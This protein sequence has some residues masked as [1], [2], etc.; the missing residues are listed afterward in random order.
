MRSLLI[1]LFALCTT[2]HAATVDPDLFAAM[3]WRM[4]G[5]FRG[6]R[7]L[8]V[9]GVPGQP[10]HFYSG[11][12]DG[13]V[14][15][16]QDAGRTWQPIFDAMPIGSIGAIAV[17]P[18]NPKVIYVGAGEADMRSDIGYGNGMYK[19]VDA[20]GTWTRIGLVDSH[21]IG[22]ILVDP[23]NPD[24]LFVAALGHAYGANEE[25]GVFRSTDGG[26]S[27]QKILYKDADTGAIDLAFGEDSKTM[28]AAMWQTR[29]PPWNVYPPSNGP[30]AGLY[31]SVDGGN[32]WTQ[33]TGHGFPS[34]GLGRI[35]IAAAPADPKRIY[36]IVDAKAGGLYRSDDSGANWS[37]VSNDSRIF[38]RGWYF[39]GI[40]VDP[41]NSDVVYSCDV[42][43]YKSVDGGKTFLPL[44]GAPGGDDYHALWID[45]DD[46]SR[47][48]T[49]A[50]QGAVVT[51]NGGLTWSSWHNQ[52][53]GQFYHVITD[54]QFPYRVYGAQQDSGAAAVPSRTT[55]FNGMNMMQFREVTAGGESG[56]I[57]PDPLNPEIIYG[58]KVAKLDTRTEQTEDVDPTFAY[59][60]IYR[61]EWTL[62]LI[63]SP[64]DPR[65]LYFANQVLFSTSD[66]GRH[67]K[68]LSSDLTREQLTIPPNLD[69]V[70]AVDTETRGPRRGV[71]YA[72]AP[73]PI[74]DHLIWTGT[75]DGL[76]W[77]TLDEGAHWQNVTPAALTPWSKVG[78]L[79]ASHFNADTAYAAIDRHRLDDYKPYIYRTRDAGRSWTLIAGG[80]PDG[81]FVNVV[82]E[83]PKKAGL[84]YAGTEL[85]MYISFNDGDS[86]QPLQLNLPTTSVRDI[87]VHEDDLVIATHG[88]A[89]WILDDIAP[90][91]RFDD[92]TP[93]TDVLLFE[94]P[95][96]YRVHPAGFTGTPLPRDE[97][98]AQNFP[99]GAVIDYFLKNDVANITL[100]I[101]NEQGEVV[102][103]FS[104]EDKPA[105]PDPGKIVVAPDWFAPPSALSNTRG[106]HRFLW[107]LHYPIPAT[108]AGEPTTNTFEPKGRWVLPGR[109][110]LKLTA[111]SS[112]LTQP[113]LIKN[114]PRVQIQ[115]TGLIQQFD[116]ARRIET[117]RIALSGPTKEVR[118][119]LTQTA[120]IRAK[121]SPALARK[122]SAFEEAIKADT[123]LE[124]AAS[125]WGG[126][127]PTKVTSFSYLDDAWAALQNTVD[128]ADAAPS[129]DVLSG[130]EKQHA[131]QQTA[132]N[133][134]E[135]TKAQ[136]LPALNKALHREHLS[137][138]TP[139]GTEIH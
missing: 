23:H 27:W 47:M 93:Q 74:R 127:P 55:N 106:M 111:G 77:L 44:R 4:I 107:D 86:W 69:P 59:P 88:R 112:A 60:E 22:R 90:L 123:E 118:N 66:G 19:S 101:V 42:A 104:S 110:T 73:S 98:M 138:L 58:G 96:A 139:S 61:S 128:D 121:A 134:W 72:I 32:T 37:Y 137:P 7:V 114:D 40:T 82:R 45:P 120:A 136:W 1:L 125:E 53:T 51:L 62:P 95:T 78:I 100:D 33:L 5:P 14:W 85:G 30:G 105:K 87:D 17:A 36:A 65:V 6:G 80:I 46:S 26:A 18:S 24:L 67:W 15:E 79:E 113:L 52:A 92:R 130:F 9:T 83:D 135:Q 20:G 115:D 13:G 57:A 84:L 3:K 56:N 25:R 132:L 54:H 108:L 8:A 28:Y 97:P 68:L 12:V 49:G 70:T 2:A 16:T 39:G 63:F 131:A 119:L 41:K 29:R 75:D 43:M 99:F 117:E 81:S 94:P 21:Q 34:E 71:I 133:K 102:R 76:I 48:I 11:S 35:G 122:L 91:R 116:L 129:P 10:N 124:A 89:F 126:P 50:D 31:K 38:E 64:R 109:Y 103:H